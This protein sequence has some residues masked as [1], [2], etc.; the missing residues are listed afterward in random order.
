MFSKDS[1]KRLAEQA[2]KAGSRLATNAQGSTNTWFAGQPGGAVLPV[3]VTPDAGCFFAAIQ[4]C[5][6]A[7]TGGSPEGINDL[8]PEEAIAKLQ[9][10]NVRLRRKA[11]AALVLEQ[12]NAQ[13]K[14]QLEE[15]ATQMVRV[16][17]GV[18]SATRHVITFSQHKCILT[19]YFALQATKVAAEIDADKEAKPDSCE[20]SKVGLI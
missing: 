12:E 4:H 17:S 7:A 8:P 2:Q 9:R 15:I 20:P 6:T 16:Y 13:L 10:Q 5:S 14:T 18:L 1:L 3:T 11:E 19:L